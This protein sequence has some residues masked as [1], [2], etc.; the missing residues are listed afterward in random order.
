MSSQ[1][2]VGPGGAIGYRY[3][4]LPVVLDAMSLPA[5]DRLQTLDDLRVIENEYVRALSEASRRG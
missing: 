4:A 2:N 5:A 3:E 1:L